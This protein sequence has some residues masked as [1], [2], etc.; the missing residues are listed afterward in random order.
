MLVAAPSPWVDLGGEMVTPFVALSWL[1]REN[2]KL[3]VFGETVNL[4]GPDESGFTATKPP[5]SLP[6]LIVTS[7]QMP[8]SIASQPTP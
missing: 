1:S 8:I 4:A 3:K 2:P 7:Y 6:S 5:G